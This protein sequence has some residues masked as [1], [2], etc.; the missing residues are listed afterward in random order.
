MIAREMD[1]VLDQLRTLLT[2]PSFVP[3]EEVEIRDE[4][5]SRLRQGWEEMEVRW[6]QAVSMMDSW[7]HR[8]SNGGASINID[9]LKQ[10]MGIGLG[11]AKAGRPLGDYDREA[12][13][14][15]GGAE[16]YPLR[17]ANG[18]SSEPPAS[19]HEAPMGHADSRDLESPLNGS[20][21]RSQRIRL[22]LESGQAVSEKMDE[23]HDELVLVDNP[24]LVNVQRRRLKAQ[25][26]SKIPKQVCS[27]L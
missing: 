24:G 14:E 17:S 27:K 4:E 12:A 6:R 11:V 8:I 16:N 3:L 19:E 20:L 23:D 21:R 7:H 26:Q 18:D 13:I 9:D 22:S 25:P 15:M 5:I 10:G 2:N 1:F